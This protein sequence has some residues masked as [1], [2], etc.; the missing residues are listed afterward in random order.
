MAYGY[1]YYT[2]FEEISFPVTSLMIR[3]VIQHNEFG[4]AKCSTWSVNVLGASVSHEEWGHAYGQGVALRLSTSGEPT[5]K[6]V[7]LW[8]NIG[9]FSNTIR[10][11]TII[12][13]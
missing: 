5:P 9:P 13:T 11:N 12:L 10:V 1:Q 8:E 7:V 3:S 2:I 6:H 4:F